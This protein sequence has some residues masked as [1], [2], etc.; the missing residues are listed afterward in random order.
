M[1]GLDPPALLAAWDRGIRQG[2]LER[3]LILLAA[4][5]DGTGGEG[6][7][8]DV[9]TREV[10]L[11]RLLEGTAGGLVWGRTVCRSCR[12]P[13]DVPVDV[14]AIARQPVHEPD[15]LLS[16]VVDG[17]EVRFRLPTSDDLGRLRGMAPA[18]ARSWLLARCVAADAGAVPEAAAEAVEAAMEEASPA[19]AIE[20]DVGCPA[21]GARTTA[22][23]DISVLLWAEIEAQAVALL[24]DVHTLATAYGWTEAQVLALSPERRA[25]Y[26]DLAGT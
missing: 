17:A 13:L 1:P 11:A 14:A 12:E 22:A 2:P 21:C 24:G 26:L 16:T 19:G 15:A 25:R 4:A 5:G 18:E 8:V 20:L 3:A 9:G 10:L 7:A 23:L 6:G